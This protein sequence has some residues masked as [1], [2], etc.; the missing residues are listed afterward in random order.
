MADGG[1][2]LRDKETGKILVR[3]GDLATVFT[4]GRD[5]KQDRWVLQLGE[6]VP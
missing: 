5:E 3:L 1:A 2:S 6:V 4:E